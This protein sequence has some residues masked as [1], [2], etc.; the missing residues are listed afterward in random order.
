MPLCCSADD[1]V[2]TDPA[3]AA[4]T[5]V[6][7]VP[8]SSLGSTP[9][10]ESS[11]RARRMSRRLSISSAMNSEAP[12]AEPATDRRL[13]LVPPNG[14]RLVPFHVIQNSFGDATQFTAPAGDIGFK[15]NSESMAIEEIDV[16]SPSAEYLN[17]LD[18][19]ITVD[20]ML[21]STVQ[22]GAVQYISQFAGRKRNFVVKPTAQV[23]AVLEAAVRAAHAGE[24]PTVSLGVLKQIVAPAGRLG[25]RWAQPDGEEAPA[26]ALGVEKPHFICEVRHG[27]VAPRKHIRPTECAVS[28]LPINR[29]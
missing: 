14:I 1:T 25:I 15:I 9:P 2:A 13:H 5:A 12:V 26:P 10:A 6:V 21:T 28:Q 8:A 4:A 18:V 17:V 11:P 24:G 22:G 19:I 7:A 20:D 29:R 16:D 23:P 3:T 27:R